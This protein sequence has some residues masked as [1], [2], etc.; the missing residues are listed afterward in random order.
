MADRLPA[1]KLTNGH[2]YGVGAGEVKREAA[3]VFAE[4]I[5]PS[6]TISAEDVQQPLLTFAGVCPDC[7]SSLIYENGCS[8]CR[9]CGYSR[10]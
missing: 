3:A 10:C 5:P 9:S 6:T 7:G 1:P 2:T 4:G 8:A